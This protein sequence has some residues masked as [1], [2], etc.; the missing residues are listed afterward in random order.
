[1]KITKLLAMTAALACLNVSAAPD[2]P[3]P[4]GPI[5][6][7]V[8]TPPG[9]TSDAIARL[10]ASRLQSELDQSVVVE[11]RV[12]ASGSIGASHVAGAAP[13]GRTLLFATGSTQ[14]VAPLLMQEVSYDPITDFTPIV[15][16]GHA[17]F[18]LFAN[19]DLPVSSLKELVEHAKQARVPLNFGTTGPAAIYAVAARVLET[20]AD[21]SFNHI[22]YKGLAPLALDVSAGRVDVSVGPIGGFLNSDK[23][24]VLS[25]L[26]D[27]RASRLP[28]VPSAAENGYPE[29][30]VPVW[31]AIFGPAGM[32]DEAVRFLGDK[33][34]AILKEPD[35]IKVVEETGV[36]VAVGDG[37]ALAG[38][39][40]SD[41]ELLSG[42]LERSQTGN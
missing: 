30:N 31:A 6:L 34:A 24:K 19:S 5:K 38:V 7:V 17:P 32:S 27:K 3:I 16:I 4:S 2:S 12:G 9:G 39:V 18:V 41:L 42:I 13:D 29:F 10:L 14:V 26:G 11:N 40:K 21:I 25:A 1:M 36:E 35:V 23:L 8:P 33:L 28:D 22:P 37:A 20:Q 15:L